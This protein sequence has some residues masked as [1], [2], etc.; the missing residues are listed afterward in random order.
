[1]KTTALIEC[2]KNGIYDIFTC[3]TDCVIFGTGNTI[4][5]AK[6]DFENSVM[7]VIAA[8][9]ENGDELPKELQNIEFEYKFYD[10]EIKYP[11]MQTH[12]LFEKMAVYA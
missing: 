6:T 1:M 8:Y 11:T 10:S 7:E 2:S 4:E 3:E 5:E 9:R 12:K